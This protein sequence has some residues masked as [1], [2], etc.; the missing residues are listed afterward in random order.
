MA[1]FWPQAAYADLDLDDSGGLVPGDG[2]LRRLLDRP[3]LALVDESCAAE[4]ALHARLQDAPRSE[5][6]TQDL[7][8]LADVDAQ[9]NYRTFLRFRDRLLQAGTL[10]ACYLGLFRSA[11][12]V[13]VAPVFVDL[14]AQAICRHLLDDGASAFE[15]RAAEMLFRPQRVMRDDG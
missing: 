1:D 8:R 3:E 2:W 11:D 15:A 5:V 4:R 12:G 14:L 9:D 13:D 7:L 6:T 10:Q